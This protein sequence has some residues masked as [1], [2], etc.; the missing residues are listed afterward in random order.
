M[1]IKEYNLSRLRSLLRRYSGGDGGQ[2]LNGQECLQ[3]GQCQVPGDRKL[4]QD[5][6]AAQIKE[7]GSLPSCNLG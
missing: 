6:G 2:E 4:S 3:D 5:Q 1:T 7:N